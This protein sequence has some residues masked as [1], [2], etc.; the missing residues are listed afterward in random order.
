MTQTHAA[1]A[2]VGQT[3]A[4][5]H[6]SDAALLSAVTE[7]LNSAANA[8]REHEME[9][10]ALVETAGG[11]ASPAP[12]GTLQVSHACPNPLC[13]CPLPTPLPP[14][15]PCPLHPQCTPA[16]LALSAAVPPLAPSLP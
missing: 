6:V 8:C 4:G 7:S 1:H 3:Y 5:Y 13:P 10:V 14:V 16:P 9:G 12:S 15:R 2:L 11:P